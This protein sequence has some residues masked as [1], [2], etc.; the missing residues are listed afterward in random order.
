[1]KDFRT[2]LAKSGASKC[3]ACEEKIKKG[4]ARIGKKEYDSQRAKMYGPYDR[5]YMVQCFVEKREELGYYDAGEAMAGFMLL[6]PEVRFCYE[7][8]M[9]F[10]LQTVTPMKMR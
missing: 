8:A 10:R 2:E 3:G 6:G 7:T 4:E 1:M 9:T 5:W